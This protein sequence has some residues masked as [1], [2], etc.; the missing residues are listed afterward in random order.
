MKPRLS[1]LWRWDGALD[2]GPF[3]LWGA[4]LFAAKF[5][6]D[7]VLIHFWFGK[8]WSNFIIHR[9]HLRVLNHVKNLSGQESQGETLTH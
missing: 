9:I 7:R 1:D 2:R 6:L 4:I 3:A 8:D 5:N